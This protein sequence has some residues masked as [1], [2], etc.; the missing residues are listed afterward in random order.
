MNFL[1][2]YCKMH[3]CKPTEKMSRTMRRK[4]WPDNTWISW[5]D[6]VEIYYFCLDPIIGKV[7]SRL[8]RITPE[9]M[10]DDWEFCYYDAVESQ[11]RIEASDI[12]N[13]KIKHLLAKHDDEHF[14]VVKKL[15]D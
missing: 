15:T 11:D 1:E 3:E 7:E 8:Y 12:K 2:L 13:K 4:S 10:K 14:R 6:E 5:T 9:L